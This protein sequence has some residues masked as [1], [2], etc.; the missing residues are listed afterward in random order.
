MDSSKFDWELKPDPE[1]RPD[2]QVLFD[3][4]GKGIAYYN[5]ELLWFD[6]KDDELSIQARLKLE[7]FRSLLQTLS[8]VRWYEQIL[9]DLKGVQ[10]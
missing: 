7:L 1:L 5:D 4:V 3:Q 6:G 10:K 2:I 9:T 8:T